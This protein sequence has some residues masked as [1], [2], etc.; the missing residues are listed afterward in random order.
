MKLKFVHIM[1]SMTGMTGEISPWN[2]DYEKHVTLFK[3][4]DAQLV[5]KFSLVFL[6]NG[7]SRELAGN[8]KN[9]EDILSRTM[10]I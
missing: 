1:N 8:D 2:M 6:C 7:T 4:S 3:C 5:L 10:N 9:L